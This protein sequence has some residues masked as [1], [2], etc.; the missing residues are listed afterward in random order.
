MAQEPSGARQPMVVTPPQMAVI[1]GLTERRLL[2]YASEGMPK[3]GR[4]GYPLVA[5]VQW[6]IDYWRKR[7][8]QTPLGD[9]RRRKVEAD[10]SS[11]ELDLARKKA[12]LAPIG[13]L[14]RAYGAA[15]ARLRSRLLAIPSKAAPQAHRMKT[16][17]EVEALL[18][19]EI[20]EALEEL[21][22]ADPAKVRT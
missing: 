4:Q 22:S 11:A 7:A 19:R 3:A 6:I 20:I 5:T 2:Q 12:E 9:A 14:S 21:I 18:R 17:S 10:A 1:V 16:V 13:T 15:C 8:T